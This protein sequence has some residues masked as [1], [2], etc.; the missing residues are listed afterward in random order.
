MVNAH[1]GPGLVQAGGAGAVGDA[2]QGAVAVKALGGLGVAGGAGE[3]RLFGG[4]L[5]G[6]EQTPQGDVYGRIR[7]VG[8]AEVAGGDGEDEELLQ[9]PALG[10]QPGL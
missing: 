4:V 6:G 8:R 1:G 3:V 10:A 5:D 9:A 7:R 2:E